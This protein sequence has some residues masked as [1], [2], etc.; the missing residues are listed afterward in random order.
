MT[1][2]ELLKPR[3]K[4]VADYP[5][6]DL[7]IET[8]LTNSYQDIWT[9]FHGLEFNERT[10]FFSDYPHLF[11]KLEWW[12]DRKVEDMPK[13][14]RN[15]NGVFEIKRPIQEYATHNAK[16]DVLPATESEY[17]EYQKS[18]LTQS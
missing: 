18:N 5:N 12:E 4:V 11:R 16:G 6:S 3:Y 14:F 17:L 7:P 13:Y 8:V 9:D 2:E 1:T 15:K 10:S